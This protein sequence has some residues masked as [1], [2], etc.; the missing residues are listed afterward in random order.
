M[1]ILKANL[2]HLYQRRGL[3]FVYALF[4]FISAAVIAG[5]YG[6]SSDSDNGLFVALLAL[7]NVSGLLACSMQIDIAI[8]PFSLCLP[9][10][11]RIKRRFL[12]IVAVGVNLLFAL[13][14]LL[15]PN[16]GPADKLIAVA[17]AFCAGMISYWIGVLVAFTGNASAGFLGFY[18]IIA[19]LTSKYDLHI[20]LEKAIVVEPAPICV[21]GIIV[22]I[23]A[24]MLLTSEG[25][26]RKHCGVNWLGLF[27]AWNWS[28]LRKNGLKNLGKVEGSLTPGLM[29]KMCLVRISNASRFVK[30]HFA[31]TV[32]TTFGGMF[33]R[34]ANSLYSLLGN[35]FIML[36]IVLAAGYLRGLG[37]IVYVIAGTL[38]I[39]LRL[40]VHST[41]L[42]A[43]GRRERFLTTAFMTLA[44]TTLISIAVTSLAFLSGI[45]DAMAFMP[46][47]KIDEHVL[48]YR[49]ITLL[50]FYVPFIMVPVGFTLQ[51]VFKRKQMPM[52]VAWVM[53]FI[54]C[55]FIMMIVV[56]ITSIWRTYAIIGL[57]TITWTVY[58]MTLWWVSMRRTVV[59]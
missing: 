6:M 40:P 37:S 26:F 57:L 1:S 42:V 5:I 14:F 21:A 18:P 20:I 47:L 36:I 10:H 39:N 30:M 46:T 29:E 24:W 31:G 28:K 8:K 16:I 13:I 7:S 2:K 23:A 48:N 35:I 52:M 15:Y 34:Q 32:Y 55:F 27:D 54:A 50:G 51:L 17:A 3:W 22:T 56:N 53:F 25:W 11:R 38:A 58:L 59:I 49:P 43:G 12:L 4:A 41:M 33:C 19:I 45:I 9:G 44:V